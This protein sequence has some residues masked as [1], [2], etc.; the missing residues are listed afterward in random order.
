MQISI[1]R[2]LKLLMN[3]MEN[4]RALICKYGTPPVKKDINHLVEP[5][6]E[7]LRHVY[8]CLILQIDILSTI[9]QPGNQ[10]SLKS[11]C[12]KT[13]KMCQYLSLGIKAIWNTKEP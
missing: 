4:L 13:H 10:N 9:S 6:I 7:E 3:Q 1:P 5:S 11:Q 2:D 8:L 12:L